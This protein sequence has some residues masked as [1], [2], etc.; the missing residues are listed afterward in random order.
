MREIKFRAWDIRRRDMYYIGDLYWFEEEGVHEIIDGK[1]I[2]HHA[3][4]IIMQYT[5][6]KDKNGKDIY[7]GD[8]LDYGYV[9]TYVDGSDL[10]NLGMDVGFYMQRDNFESWAMLEVGSGYEVLGNVHQN[11][12]LL[13]VK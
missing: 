3:S 2:G 10:A 13:E 4:Y 12:K 5:G 11:P 1:G 6:I 9:V 7:K 8:I